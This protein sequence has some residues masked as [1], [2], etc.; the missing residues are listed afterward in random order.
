MRGR[1]GRG[2][3][4]HNPLFTCGVLKGKGVG[5]QVGQG[6]HVRGFREWLILEYFVLTSR[7]SLC[8]PSLGERSGQAG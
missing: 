1:G 2:G 5:M 3:G 6:L 4:R 8:L 7:A